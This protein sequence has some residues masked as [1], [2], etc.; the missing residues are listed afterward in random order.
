MYPPTI[1][2]IHPATVAALI[3]VTGCGNE[4][5]LVKGGKWEGVLSAIIVAF[6]NKHWYMMLH[7]Y[8]ALTTYDDAVIVWPTIFATFIT[9]A[10]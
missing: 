5:T 4:R 1:Q 7:T 3:S 2:S 8:F 6:N 9:R 10:I